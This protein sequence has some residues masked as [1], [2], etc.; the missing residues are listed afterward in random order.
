[1]A[2]LLAAAAVWTVLLRGQRVGGELV[3]GALCLLPEPSLLEF[4][5][6]GDSQQHWQRWYRGVNV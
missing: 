2:T 3:V 6:G 5:N 1:V 4:R